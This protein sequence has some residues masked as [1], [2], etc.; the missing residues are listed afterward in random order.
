MCEYCWKKTSTLTSPALSVGLGLYRTKVIRKDVQY[1][2]QNTPYIP[3]IEYIEH[4]NSSCKF[5]SDFSR[6]MEK[7]NRGGILLTYYWYVVKKR[8]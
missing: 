8:N 6:G 1:E 4:R 7:N 2:F 3:L 5:E